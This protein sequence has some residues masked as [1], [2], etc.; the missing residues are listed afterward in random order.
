MSQDKL[1]SS[2]LAVGALGLAGLLGEKLEALGVYQATFREF[3]DGPIL[4]QDTFKNLVVTGGKNYL[5]DNGMAGSA[6]TAAF[7][8]G[9]I[10]STSYSA[11]A[12]ADTAASHAGWLEGGGANAPAYSGGA[13]KT[14]A[15]AAASAGSKALSA[16]LVFTFTSGGTVKGCFLS[17]ASGLDA[18]TGTLFSAGLFTGGDQPVISGNTLT[19]TYTLSV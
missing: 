6:Y 1:H 18:T 11:I 15:W 16:G 12:A 2:A 14:A 7:Y 4:R 8:M 17:T 3:A 10:T 5:L 13:R 9:L 19:V